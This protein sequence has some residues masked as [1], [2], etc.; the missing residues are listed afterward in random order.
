[1]TTKKDIYDV[2]SYTDTELYNILDISNPTEKELEAKIIFLINKYANIQNESGYQLAIFFQE[3]Y[4]RFFLQEDI[5]QEEEPNDTTT[6]QENF[7][8][9]PGSFSGASGFSIQPINDPTN[10]LKNAIAPI[11]T[12]TFDYA[13]NLSGTN[14]LLKQTIKRVI[15]IDSQ[16][17][18]K[19]FQPLSTNFTFNLSEPLKDVVSLKLYSVNIPYTWYTISSDY[20]SNFFYLKGNSPGIDQGNH[21]YQ[22]AIN[23]GNYTPTELVTAITASITNLKTQYSDVSFGQTGITYSSTS[24]KMTFTADIQMVYNESYYNVVFDPTVASFLKLSQPDY[25]TTYIYHFNSIYGGIQNTY[26]NGNLLSPPSYVNGIPNTYSFDIIRYVPLNLK[27][28]T[29]DGLINVP[30][31]FSDLSYNYTILQTIP[32]SFSQT[33]DISGITHNINTALQNTSPLLSTSGF[34]LNPASNTYKMTVNLDRMKISP[35]MIPNEKV[36]IVFSQ[37]DPIRKTFGFE[38]STEL[39]NII[40]TDTITTIDT[41]I[42]DANVQ[43]QFKCIRPNYGFGAYRYPIEDYRNFETHYNDFGINIPQGTYSI[44]QLSDYYNTFFKNPQN[45]TVDSLITNGVI[46][47]GSKLSFSPLS[48]GN[49]YCLDVSFNLTKVFD[50]SKYVLNFDMIHFYKNNYNIIYRDETDDLTTYFGFQYSYQLNETNVIH[51]SIPSH[52]LDVSYSRIP[53][54]VYPILFTFSPNNRYTN[55][56]QDDND[57]K[58]PYLQIKLIPRPVVYDNSG[59]AD[60]TPPST[61]T[62]QNGRILY[63]TYNNTDFTNLI[64]DINYTFQQN[65]TADPHF[66]YSKSNIVYD[67]ESGNVTLTFILTNTLTESD[68][69]VIFINTENTNTKDIT[70]P[71][72]IWNWFGVDNSVGYNLSANSNI[73]GKSLPIYERYLPESSIDFYIGSNLNGIENANTFSITIPPQNYSISSFMNTVNTALNNDGISIALDSKFYL[74]TYTDFSGN[75][76]NNVFNM[77]MNINKIYTSKD[78]NL[79]FYD[80]FS[81]IKC[82]VGAS[83]V[84]NTTWDNTLGWILGFRDYTSYTLIESNLT[85]TTTNVALANNVYLQSYSGAYTYVDTI[86]TLPNNTNIVRTKIQLTGDTTVTT[87]LYNYFLIVLDD[88][89]QNHLNDG[90]VTICKPETQLPAQSYAYK[91]N[92]ICDPITKQVVSL[93]TSN[94]PTNGLTQNQIYALNAIQIANQTSNNYNLNYSKGPYVQDIFGIVPIKT[95]GLQTGQYY[96]EFGGTLQNQERQYFGPVNIHRMHIQLINDKG[97]AVNLNNSDWSFSLICE[98]L[99]TSS[100]K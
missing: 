94:V 49:S 36:A 74:D 67:Y 11:A 22:I 4:K 88:F 99:Y 19:M 24:I 46:M 9:F 79:V 35:T 54:I 92:Q 71:I 68:Y 43:I 73:I 32:V 42:L 95:A 61:T 23:P 86:D 37:D 58:K 83:S 15:S 84:S 26:I 47:T 38:I 6:L 34:A 91:A 55:G 82:Y 78:Y 80:P 56:I 25:T 17:R 51:S 98:Q 2:S 50:Q 76:F 65:D 40:G 53:L 41:F 8:D 59:N 44:A 97:T 45:A 69:K 52:L 12:Q 33:N 93:G 64:A 96:V 20:G 14:P 21:D 89:I 63:Y 60:H 13:P 27:Q 57:T 7:E 100:N 72:N 81:F 66:D 85:L 77:R 87:N 90:L 75:V 70:Q 3:I 10:N 48:N 29:S 39:S 62:D 31:E 28:I 30:Y 1:M 16:Y 5:P 18:N